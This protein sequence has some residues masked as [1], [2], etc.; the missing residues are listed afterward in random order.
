MQRR[1]AVE[2][3][4]DE[5]ASAPRPELETRSSAAR[6]VRRR[7]RYAR[8][9]ARRPAAA[10]CVTSASAPRRSGAK[11]IWT[12]PPRSGLG[13]RVDEGRIGVDEGAGVLSAAPRHGEERTLEVDP[14]ERAVGHEPG[15][16]RHAV[17]EG[18]AGRRDQRSDH[19]GG[20]VVRRTPSTSDKRTWKRN[21]HS[22]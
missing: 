6:A 19:R 9:P 1:H 15:A 5:G 17:E 22:R 20:A 12:T 10:S 2:D 13:Q 3:V 18:R 21:R 4:G 11:V 7:R 16:R 8:P 14:R